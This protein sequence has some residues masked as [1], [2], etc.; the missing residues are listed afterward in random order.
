VNLSVKTLD[1]GKKTHLVIR[2]E[3]VTL[4]RRRDSIIQRNQQVQ[5]LSTLMRGFKKELENLTGTV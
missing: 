4:Q 3:D 5:T 1:L 2:L